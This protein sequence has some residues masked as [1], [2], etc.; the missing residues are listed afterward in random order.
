ML[1]VVPDTRRQVLTRAELPFSELSGRFAA[2]SALGYQELHLRIAGSLVRMRIVGQRWMAIVRAAMGHLAVEEGS[3]A[4]ALCIDG[5]DVEET[6]IAGVVPAQPDLAAPPILMR[7][8]EDR[9][10]VGEERAHSLVWLS[11]RENRIVGCIEST[12]LLNL[13]ERARPFHKLIS[14]WLENNGVQFVHSGLIVHRDK[15]VLF[16]G[17]GGTGKST[18]SVACLRSGMSYLGDDFLGLGVEQ[19]R[20]IG[21]GLYATCLLNVHHIERFPDL[22]SLGY[23]PNHAHEDKFV[24]YLQS[25]F[26]GAVHPRATIDALVLPRVV[27]R[28]HSSF[29][30]ASK[31][32]AL[33]AIAP[34]SVMYLPYPNRAAFERLV[35]LVESTPT[36]WLEMGSVM[37]SIPSAVRA[38]VDTL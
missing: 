26:P 29:V 9:G 19:E 14:A 21:H 4:P 1:T 2:A 28:E 23:A 38:L 13:D 10:E 24:L 12:G 25:A 30:P 11:R 33:K 18:A 37:E 7:T 27:H 34:T 35:R 17:N 22:Q 32:A 8:S 15:G 5:W 31:A 3:Q 36:F 6:G 20:F 16:V